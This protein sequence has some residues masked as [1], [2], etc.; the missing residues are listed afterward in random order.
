MLIS[1]DGMGL[2]DTPLAVIMDLG[3]HTHA[4]SFDTKQVGLVSSY[5]PATGQ[6]TVTG[7]E[8]LLGSSM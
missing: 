7:R 1:Q 6:L 2:M 3:F 5:D 4:V 8:C